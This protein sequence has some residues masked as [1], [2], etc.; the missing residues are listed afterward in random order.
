[1]VIEARDTYDGA[2][3]MI[4]TGASMLSGTTQFEASATGTYNVKPDCSGSLQLNGL[5]KCQVS[6][7]EAR[8]R[9][10]GDFDHWLIYSLV[11]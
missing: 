3:H 4:E 8:D 10:L 6:D 5:A 2:G 7:R 1:M 9:N 11:P